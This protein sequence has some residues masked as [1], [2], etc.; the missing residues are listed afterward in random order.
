[1]DYLLSLVD[2]D[3]DTIV[4]AIKDLAANAEKVKSQENE[5]NDLRSELEK[6]KEEKHYLKNK[7]DQKYDIIEDMEN[8]LDQIERKYKETK[9]KL[10]LKEMDL[11]R[12]E[13]LI[14]EQVEEIN[15]LRDN[16]QSMVVQISEN[17]RMEHKINVQSKVIKE[18]K[19]KQNER[20]E[21]QRNEE[22]IVQ[23]VKEIENLKDIN[24]EKEIKLE[25][26]SNECE[27][28]KAK[29]AKLEKRI[30]EEKEH[31]TLDEEIRSISKCEECDAVFAS[32]GDMKKHLRSIDGV[33]RKRS[34]LQVKLYEIEKKIADQK[35]DLS[36]KIS[37]LK[38]KEETCKCV[39]WCA[40]NHIKHSYK[41]S[42]SREL[43]HKFQNLINVLTLTE[44][45]QIYSFKLCEETFGNVERLRN[46]MKTHIGET[47]SE[48]KGNKY[49]VL[50]DA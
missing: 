24:E 1:M 5:I 15:I 17:V 42:S 50:L 3:Q 7:L 37:N 4:D 34:A 11:K 30:F 35:L 10:E 22:E 38:E 44:K 47:T 33:K 19:E 2:K 49:E 29:L 28:V 23:L 45:P 31:V 32:L 14:I 39:G 21:D 13:M 12:L 25:N 40:I 20:N 6:D 8:E 43:D 26:V 46:H 41:K 16:N 48:K 36:L 9:N 27:S 18:L